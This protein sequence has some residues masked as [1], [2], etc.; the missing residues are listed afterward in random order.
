MN[1]IALALNEAKERAAAEVQIEI[2]PD[3]AEVRA[4]IDGHTHIVRD[5]DAYKATCMAAEACGVELED[6]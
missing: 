2:G 1:A 4:T 3:G 6:G 5:P